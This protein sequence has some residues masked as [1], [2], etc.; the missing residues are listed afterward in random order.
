MADANIKDLT[1]RLEALE[2]RDSTHDKRWNAI[3]DA[4]AQNDQFT[5]NVNEAR[6]S[7]DENLRKAI[8]ALAERVKALEL[9]L[10]AAGKK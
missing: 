2:K 10:A 9:Q 6:K 4:L 1:K 5:I 7:G 3:G 8:D